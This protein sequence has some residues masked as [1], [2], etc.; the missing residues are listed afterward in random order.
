MSLRSLFIITA[1]IALVCAVWVSLERTWF[2][3]A[4]EGWEAQQ[5][6][7]KLIADNGWSG[8]INPTHYD[9]EVK[10]L[11]HNVAEEDLEKTFPLLHKISW[12]R[13][14]RMYEPRLSEAA[15]IRWQKEF[16]N[17]F[18]TVYPVGDGGN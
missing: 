8:Q 2:G 18:I 1:A 9:C 6:F 10:I 14:V 17:C 11:L 13:S 15:K 16:P 3:P 7:D 12:L 4:R 5:Q